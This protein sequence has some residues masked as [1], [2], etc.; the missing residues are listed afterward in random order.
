[1]EWIKICTDHKNLAYFRT[2][3]KLNCCQA[4]WSL[5]LSCFH[6]SL[7]H[8]P[9]SQMGKPDALSRHPDHPRG[10]KDNSE[11]TLLDPNVFEIHQ[12]EAVLV[13]GPEADL[14]DRIRQSKDLDKP[15]VKAL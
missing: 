6:F 2:A 9:G 13:H 1:M 7:I 3:Q 11:V 8:C 4:R 10:H 12:S 5:Y 14:L 15:V